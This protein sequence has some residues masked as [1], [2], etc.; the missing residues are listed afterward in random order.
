[1]LTIQTS[2]VGAVKARRED[3]NHATTKAAMT[4]WVPQQCKLHLTVRLSRSNEGWTL[5]LRL[6]APKE[7]EH[8]YHI[9]ILGIICETLFMRYI[10]FIYL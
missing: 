7:Q 6:E 4:I 1:L 9:S 5:G 3:E 10:I 8:W 2:Q